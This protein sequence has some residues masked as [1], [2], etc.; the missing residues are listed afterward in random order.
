MQRV[1]TG[2]KSE[3]L[4]RQLEYVRT[5]NRC[6]FCCHHHQQLL[7]ALQ[8]YDF[9]VTQDSSERWMKYFAIL[10]I[11]SNCAQYGMLRTK[12]SFKESAIV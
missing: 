6:R 7:K 5:N 1:S 8:H 11:S 12:N 10:I 2:I 3:I 4:S 9:K